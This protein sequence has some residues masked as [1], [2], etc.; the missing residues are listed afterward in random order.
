MNRKSDTSKIEYNNLQETYDKRKKRVYDLGVKAIDILRKELKVVS[1]QTVSAKTKEIDTEGNGN[2]PNTIRS[3]EK[4]QAYFAE[5]CTSKNRMPCR[6]SQM[7]I[8][9]QNYTFKDIV[10]IETLI[11]LEGG[12]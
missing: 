3:N 9:E 8:E 7:A 1:Y 6:A 5:Y 12:I 4:L 10:Q 11:A 2:H